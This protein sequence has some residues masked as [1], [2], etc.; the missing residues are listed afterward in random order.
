MINP[1]E[2][3]TQLAA[4]NAQLSVS[5][6]VS[7]SFRGSEEAQHIHPP[8]RIYTNVGRNRNDTAHSADLGPPQ[9]FA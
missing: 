1:L 5:P 7:E 9:L 4:A 6:K 8:R 2:W 3:P